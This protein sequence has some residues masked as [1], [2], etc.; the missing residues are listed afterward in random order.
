MYP[1]RGARGTSSDT[2]GSLDVMKFT[3]GIQLSV[4]N[5]VYICC[6]CCFA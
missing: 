5:D 2:T 4:I 3:G 1:A 6:M